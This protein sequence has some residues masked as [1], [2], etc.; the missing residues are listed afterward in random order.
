M[1][2]ISTIKRYGQLRNHIIT[3]FVVCLFVL[4]GHYCAESIVKK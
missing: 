4:F 1:V 3:F 2:D